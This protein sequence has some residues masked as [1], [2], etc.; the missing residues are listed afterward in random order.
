[1][2]APL[3][4]LPILACEDEVD[5]RE[6]EVGVD[7]RDSKT[8]VDNVGIR[9]DEGAAKEEV[10]EVDEV[11]LPDVVGEEVIKA[12]GKALTTVLVES[13][14]GK[15]IGVSIV[16]DG[17]SDVE[18]GNDFARVLLDAAEMVV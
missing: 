11:A 4:L 8:V 18:D 12:D 5:E 9:T 1:M 3:L 15:K 6:E 13:S 7:V 2:L 17:V 10:V 16:E 14:E